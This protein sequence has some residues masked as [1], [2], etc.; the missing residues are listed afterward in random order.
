[1]LIWRP[2]DE[3]CSTSSKEYQ[4]SRVSSI[5]RHDTTHERK[6]T[7]LHI[8]DNPYTTK[9]HRDLIAASLNQD[10][11]STFDGLDFFDKSGPQPFKLA[12]EHKS[13]GLTYE[14]GK[15]SARCFICATLFNCVIPQSFISSNNYKLSVPIF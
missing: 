10:G 2:L 15:I 13:E 5:R 12:M 8:R 14:R 9:Q 6:V 7:D 4:S 3:P 1:M 11:W